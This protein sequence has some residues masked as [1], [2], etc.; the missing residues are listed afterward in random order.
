M[1]MAPSGNDNNDFT[2]GADA[3]LAGQDTSRLLA[4]ELSDATQ[5]DCVACVMPAQPGD[6]NNL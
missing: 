1:A 3:L 2:W 5:T 4:G 6:S